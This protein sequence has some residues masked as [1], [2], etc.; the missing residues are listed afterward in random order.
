MATAKQALA[1]AR[2]KWGKHAYVRE[3]PRALPPAMR[4]ERRKH[5]AELVVRDTELR[6][7]ISKEPYKWVSL[8]KAAE[9]CR[10][11]NAQEP[12][13]SQL[14]EEVT[15]ARAFADMLA[16]RVA[17]KK[18]I[19]QLRCGLYFKRWSA[20][21]IA[22]VGGVQFAH[23]EVEADTIAELLAKIEPEKQTA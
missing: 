22:G 15:K 10:D 18:E 9:F 4:E 19:E 7:T 6:D 23:C 5:V 21:H 17:L 3:H 16:E 12:S 8:I 1:A 13:L 11:V 14:G 2:R 20:G